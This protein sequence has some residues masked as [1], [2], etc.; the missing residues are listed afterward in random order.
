MVG[1][2]KYYISI[3]LIQFIGFKSFECLAH[4][5]FYSPVCIFIF[6]ILNLII[7]DRK[8]CMMIIHRHLYFVLFIVYYTYKSAGFLEL[9]RLF[10]SRCQLFLSCVLLSTKIISLLAMFLYFINFLKIHVFIIHA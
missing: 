5:Y 4:V 3:Y 8:L 9:D 10:T 1:C 2:H 7:C 6:N